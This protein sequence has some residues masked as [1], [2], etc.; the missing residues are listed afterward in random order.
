MPWYLV[1]IIQQHINSNSETIKGH[2]FIF[3]QASNSFLNVLFNDLLFLHCN[4]TYFL[5]N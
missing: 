3:F 2:V 4:K 5:L 1:G